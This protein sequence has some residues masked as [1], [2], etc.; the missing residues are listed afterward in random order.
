MQISK[1]T[2]GPWHPYLGNFSWCIATA[3][4]FP[5]ARIYSCDD[6]NHEA[7]KPED[8][9]NA[10]LMASSPELLDALCAA[11]PFVEDA[12]DSQDFKPGYVKGRAKMVRDAIARAIGDQ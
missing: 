8:E 1:Y 10:R 11:L 5:V 7:T 2:P 3:K 9:A 4:D 12:L 6:K